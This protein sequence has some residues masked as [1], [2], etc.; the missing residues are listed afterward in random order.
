M[1]AAT[2]G[3]SP[4][5][6]VTVAATRASGGL[7]TSRIASVAGSAASARTAVRPMIPPT[8]ALR[9]RPPRPTTCVTPTPARSS[10]TAASCAPV[11]AAATTATAPVR[12]ARGAT[13][14]AKPRQ[15]RPSIAVPAPGPM[16]SRPSCSA[17]VLSSTSAAT[18]TLSL[19]SRTCRPSLSALWVSRAAWSPG[20]EIT[21]TLPPARRASASVWVRAGA[22][23]ASAPVSA[24]RAENIA[25]RPASSAASTAS[26]DAARTAST[27]SP[28]PAPDRS[29]PS[30]PSCS[31]VSRFAGV[32]IAAVAQSTPSTARIARVPES[33]TTESRYVSLT[34]RTRVVTPAPPRSACRCG[35][36][37]G[38]RRRRGRARRG[39]PW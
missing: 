18:G 39:R 32:A 3:V 33:W 29:S 37:D 25:S 21:A 11:P 15:V 8:S 16:T 19:N 1:S 5:C 35:R 10:S 26:S 24:A 13:T 22:S 12:S 36:R 30:K 28:G 14:L 2:R 27:R 31:S 17:R 23:A 20:T 6:A 9:S 34:I 7:E 4:A 38:C